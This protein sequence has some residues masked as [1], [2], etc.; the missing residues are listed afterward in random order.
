MSGERESAETPPPAPA[1]SQP[2]PSPAPASSAPQPDEATRAWRFWAKLA[3][4]LFFVGY[5]VAFVVGNSKSISVDFVFSTANVS[6]IWSVLLLLA[7]GFGAGVLVSH[8]YG[9]R[10]RKQARKT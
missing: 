8:L 4:L 5:A 7:V 2:E 10:R 3:A 1:L 6:L 9:Q